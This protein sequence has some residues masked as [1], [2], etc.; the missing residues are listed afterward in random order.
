[1]TEIGKGSSNGFIAS[2]VWYADSQ[3]EADAVVRKC[4]EEHARGQAEYDAG[5]ATTEM[6]VGDLYDM[7][8][9]EEAVSR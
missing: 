8:S 1:M 5:H 9:E 4:D 7:L 2:Y 6:D 3:A